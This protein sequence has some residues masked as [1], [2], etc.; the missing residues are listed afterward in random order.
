MMWFTKKK[1]KE[2]C[3]FSILSY[4]Q[5]LGLSESFLLVQILIDGISNE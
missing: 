3:K 1:K 2:T 4:N 5:K